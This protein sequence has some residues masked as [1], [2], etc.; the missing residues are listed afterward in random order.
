MVQ[1]EGANIEV[2]AWGE[3]HLPG[4][5]LLHGSRAG[6]DWW[7]T[8]A[9]RLMDDYRVI[10]L[11]SSGMGGSDWRPSYSITQFARELIAVAQLQGLYERG[12]KPIV[13]AHSFGG[14]V[15]LRACT[16][17]PER[18]G[19]VV[20]IDCLLH[21]L[22]AAEQP[23][24]AQQPE[25]RRTYATIADALARFR[26]IPSRLTD[27]HWALDDIARRSLR[28]DPL[29]GEWSWHFDNALFAKIAAEDMSDFDSIRQP[30]AIVRGEFSELY[31]G[32][33]R[34][35]VEQLF[36]TS[37]PDIVVPEAGHHIMIDQPLALVA[38]LRTLVGTW[39]ACSRPDRRS[40]LGCG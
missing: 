16:L 11:S 17:D 29:T 19:G 27:C 37:I 31:D 26:L 4:I 24:R 35:R 34:A 32:A 15:A 2:L 7:S 12:G 33:V 22:K 13:V 5:L 23:W 14:Y 28:H 18:I 25:P 6:A 10:A 3:R 36:G 38:T 1:I 21:D 30:V 20:L 9:P 39:S 40:R 8:I